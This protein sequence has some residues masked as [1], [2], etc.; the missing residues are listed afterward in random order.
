[1]DRIF[2]DNLRF[3][4]ELQGVFQKD[5][6]EDLEVDRTSISHWENGT[7]A[8]TF[9][10]LCKIADYF[11]VTTDSLLGREQ[12]KQLSF[13]QQLCGQLSP[14][15]YELALDWISQFFDENEIIKIKKEHVNK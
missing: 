14:N 5:L 7:H 3:I 2:G 4:R 6:A 13:L 1:M 11:K 15:E 8:P 9:D 10:M 12:P